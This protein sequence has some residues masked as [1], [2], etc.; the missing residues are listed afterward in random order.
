M[1]CSNE[2]NGG[3]FV[4]Y[5]TN[6]ATNPTIARVLAALPLSRR[7]PLLAEVEDDGA[8]DVEEPVPGYAADEPASLAEVV[9]EPPLAMAAA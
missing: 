4:I 9:E 3:K 2:K 6:P 8:P 7:A 1:R 5:S